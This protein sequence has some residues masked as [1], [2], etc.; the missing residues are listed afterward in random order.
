MILQTHDCFHSSQTAVAEYS[1][2]KYLIF[3]FKSVF[4]SCGAPD[5]YHLTAV[6]GLGQCLSG[7]VFTAPQEVERAEGMPVG[8]SGFYKAG[9][10]TR[11]VAALETCAAVMVGWELGE[12][13]EQN[14]PWCAQRFWQM[15]PRMGMAQHLALL[16][17]KQVTVENSSSIPLGCSLNVW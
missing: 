12:Q 3:C 11:M 2:A 14:R 8:W 15:S 1:A 6:W 5:R 17:I 7:L 10:G 13:A 9:R 4:P 16:C